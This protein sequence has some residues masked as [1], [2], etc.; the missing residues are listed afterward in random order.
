MNTT[1]RQI[2]NLLKTAIEMHRSGQLESA[3]KLYENV[4]SHDENNAEALHWLGLLHHQAGDQT[5]AAHLIGRAVELRPN[6]HLYHLNLAEVYRALRE[7]APAAESCRAALRLWPAY[8]EALC[9]LG[10]TLTALKRY[11]EAVESLRRAVELRPN[12]AVATNNLGITLRELGR[13]SEALAQFRRAVELEPAFAAARTNLG[14]ALLDQNE[15]EEALAHCQEAVRLDPDSAEM[16]DNLGNA[17]SALDRLDDAWAA[18]W[19]ALRLDVDL[20]SANAHIGLILQ[21]RG[22][23]DE[24]LPWLKKAVE[25]EPEDTAIWQWLAGLH[26]ERDEPHESIPCWRRVLALEPRRVSAH[27]ALGR[28]LQDEGRLDEARACYLAAMALEPDLPAA[29]LNLGGLHELVGAMDQAEAAYRA[30]IGHQPDFAIPH[31]RLATLLRGKLP[32]ADLAALEARLADPTLAENP[33][34]RLLFA[35]AHVLDALGDYS[36]AADCLT[37]ANALSRPQSKERL[38]YQAAPHEHF[39]DGLL[40][41]FD[42]GLFARLDGAGPATVRPVFVFGL[43][44]SGTTLI[45]QVL[46]SH[47]QVHGAG[48]LRL[49]RRSF[50]AIPD[51]VGRPGPTIDCVGDL[52]PVAARDLAA[53]H[54]ERLAEIDSGR[55]PRIVDKMP[56]NYLYL[57]L[58]AILFPRATFIHCR[59]D[60]RDVAV[61]CWMTDFSTIRWANDFD[62]IASRFRQYRRLMDH[63][64]AV[65]PVPIHHVDYEE[66]VNDL[67]SV[68]AR[69]LSACGLDWEPACLEFHRTLRPVRTAS[70]TQVRQPVYRHSVARWRNYEPALAELFAALFD[71]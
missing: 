27:L 58:L 44:R 51:A 19:E 23:L 65:L 61:S 31:G 2:R 3:A 4:L 46:A 35:L 50:D 13:G 37:R 52:D 40:R 34:G 6:A 18:H 25:L 45:E 39:V 64:G 41:A 68:A 62:H 15:A 56:D 53:L 22:H 36:R 54:M 9:T 14:L 21:R 8:P 55:S 43:P 32:A 11:D 5:L 30:A 29:H 12:D 71:P 48:E 57:G 47:S 49:A 66:T 20:A 59:R 69:L 24:A 7:F 1:T 60:L 38:E 70:I 42:R 10:T 16:R 33:R 26:D 28:A 67:E 63:W 17:L